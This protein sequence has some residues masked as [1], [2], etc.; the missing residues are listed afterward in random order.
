MIFVLLSFHFALIIA[1]FTNNN[2]VQLTSEID[3]E[4][5]IGDFYVN[6]HTV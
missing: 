6:I 2:I 3:C 4:K 1:E 5:D